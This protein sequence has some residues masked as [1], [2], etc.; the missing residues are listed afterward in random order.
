M[1]VCR[2]MCSHCKSQTTVTDGS[3]FNKTRTELRVWFAGI[4][5]ITNQKHG[6]SAPGLQR[7]LGLGSYETA[8]TKLH[9]DGH[10]KSPTLSAA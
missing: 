8:W 4:W 10:S 2:L 1:A 9:P 3:I 5:Y 6:I 7:V